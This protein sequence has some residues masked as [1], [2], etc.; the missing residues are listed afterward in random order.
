[1]IVFSEISK[2]AKVAITGDG[3]DEIFY[4]YNR[5]KYYNLWQKGLKYFKPIL[6]LLKQKI[7]SS[8]YRILILKK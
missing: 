8:I 6:N 5:Y 1:M 4:G 2:F 3:G 7:K